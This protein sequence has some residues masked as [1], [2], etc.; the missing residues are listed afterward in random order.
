MADPFFPEVIDNSL[1]ETF[2]TCPTK[3]NREYFQHWKPATPNVHLHAGGSYAHGLEAAR[4]AFYRDGKPEAEAI[5]LGA[6]ALIEFYGNFECPPDSAK[7][8]EGT[9]GAF[10]FYF[11]RYP[12]RSDPA[13]PV[14]FSD[15][16]LGV[17]FNFA[18]PIDFPHPVT[19]AP[20][21]YT[22]RFDMLCDY[23]SSIF[24]EDD[25][26]TTQLGASWSRKWDLRSQFTGYCWG[27]KKHNLP[28]VG[29]LVRGVSIL[30]RGYDT[31]QA[32]TYRQ[33]WQ[34]DEWYENLVEQVLPEMVRMWEAQ[35]WGLALNDACDAYGGCPQR[36]VCLAEP[37]NRISWLETKFE[38]RH[39]DPVTRKETRL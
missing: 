29:F 24:G 16:R 23:Q 34:I 13:T 7:S 5:A 1:V 9:L 19:G 33:Q 28:I 10:E 3:C 21:L 27:A 18:E 35:K 39:W 4:L 30:K 36:V 37:V 8:L 31:Q 12:M 26:T 32:I 14:K 22:G 2:L 38:R 20:L 11:D 6:K 17:E 15:G 25:K